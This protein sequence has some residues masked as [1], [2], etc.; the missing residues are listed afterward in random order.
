MVKTF[1]PCL[2]VSCNSYLAF[3]LL[4]A[5]ILV[6]WKKIIQISNSLKKD[7]RQNS[8]VILITF[9]SIFPSFSVFSSVLYL[10]SVAQLPLILYTF[11]SS[12]FARVQF[13]TRTRL[14][15]IEPDYYT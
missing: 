3:F 15:Y 14:L 10:V 12:V 7:N 1:N 8:N 9:L 11:E 5:S 2:E 4:S 6:A 13:H